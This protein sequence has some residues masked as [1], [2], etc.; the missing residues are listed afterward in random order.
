VQYLTYVNPLRYF[1][2]IVRNLF[3]K[4]V[5]VESLWPQ[6][7]ALFLFGATILVLSAV[8]FHKKLD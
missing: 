8:R 2:Q 7:V 3:L 4:G 1:M 6:I 5:G